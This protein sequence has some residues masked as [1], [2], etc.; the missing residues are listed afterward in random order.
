ME[1]SLP[2]VLSPPIDRRESLIQTGVIALGPVAAGLGL[3]LNELTVAAAVRIPTVFGLSAA[4]MVPA[5]YIGAALA[6][7]APPLETFLRAT[8]DGFRASS[9]LLLG[10]CPAIAFLVSTSSVDQ[11]MGLLGQGVVLTAALFGLR[12]MYAKTFAGVTDRLRS[13]VVFGVW[14]LVTLGIGAHLYLAE[15]I[16]P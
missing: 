1:T 15:A 8:R 12:A 10:L 14:A 3:G 11:S 13:F 9:V 4:L 16:I 5:L 2:G 6:G 7:I